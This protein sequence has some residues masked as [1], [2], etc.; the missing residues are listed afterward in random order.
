MFKRI[1]L[2]ALLLVTLSVSSI[3]QPKNS[4]A[5]FSNAGTAALA[6]F[7][8][9]H[10][11]SFASYLKSIRPR[12][13]SP[14]LK[15]KYVAIFPKQDVVTPSAEGMD[16][17]AALGPILEYYGRSSVVD[18]KVVRMGQPIVLFLAGAAVV[19]SEEALN[20]FSAKEL[21]AVVAHE[22]G[23]EYFWSEWQ[24]ARL[25]KKYEKMQEIELRCDGM[26]IIA[27][28]QLGLNPQTFI[29][30][31]TKLARA[32]GPRIN[33]EYYTP[34]EE[35]VKFCQTIMKMVNE[36]GEVFGPTDN[37]E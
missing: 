35:R 11:L 29:K 7:D 15:A 3:A 26:A 5:P 19:I 34:F 23:H 8:Q 36:R 30:A 27:L 24:T 12:Q 6:Y 17:L 16:K 20:L 31:I 1:Y 4:V 21:Q 10:G 25:N 32:Y 9:I 28:S 13:I 18:V 14:E 33:M 37:K 2:T 22:M